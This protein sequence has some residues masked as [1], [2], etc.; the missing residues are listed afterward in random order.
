VHESIGG[1]NSFDSSCSRLLLNTVR[2]LRFLALNCLTGTLFKF[3]IEL[4]ICPCPPRPYVHVMLMIF[5]LCGIVEYRFY[6]HENLEM[7]QS[8]PYCKLRIL[9]SERVRV[10]GSEAVR[11]QSVQCRYPCNFPAT[12]PSKLQPSQANRRPLQ[13]LLAASRRSSVMQLM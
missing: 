6:I 11:D 1:F 7:H 9:L 4:Y 5:E 10:A 13:V 12:W 3:Q 8:F 2:C